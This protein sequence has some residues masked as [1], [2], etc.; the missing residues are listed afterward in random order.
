MQTFMNK[1]KY[2]TDALNKRKWLYFRYSYWKIAYFFASMFAL[3]LPQLTTCRNIPF[4]TLRNI[5]EQN[6]NLATSDGGHLYVSLIKKI[7]FASVKEMKIY[8]HNLYIY[9]Y[10][11]VYIHPYTTSSFNISI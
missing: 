3:A 10:I 7:P 5:S 2:I 9:I 6:P 11:Y 4:R 1:T 8:M